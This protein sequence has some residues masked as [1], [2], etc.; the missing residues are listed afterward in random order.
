MAL[1]RTGGISFMCF[2]IMLSFQSQNTL[3]RMAG[4]NLAVFSDSSMKGA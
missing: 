3:M 1:V 4:A 2:K